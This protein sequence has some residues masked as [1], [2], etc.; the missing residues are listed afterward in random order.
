MRARWSSSWARISDFSTASRRSN[1]ELRGLA[2]GGDAR[3]LGLRLPGD[4][5]AHDRG[6]LPGP[7]GLDLAFLVEPRAL[8]LPVDLERLLLRLEVAGP[9]RHHRALLDVVPGLAA[10]LDLLDEAGE[11]LGV[12]TVR[13]G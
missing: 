7:H 1:L 9:D 8:A 6:A 12:E 11:P 4:L 13:G 5:L 3:L 2:L 10:G